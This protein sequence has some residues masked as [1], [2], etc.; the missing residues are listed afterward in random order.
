MFIV[1]FKF[2]N[3]DLPNYVGPFENYKEAEYFRS[4]WQYHFSKEKGEMSIERVETPK[5]PSECRL[6]KYAK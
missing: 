6:P 5:T 1:I 3:G 4:Q 2:A